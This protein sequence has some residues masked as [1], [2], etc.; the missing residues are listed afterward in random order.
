LYITMESP[1]SPSE[2]GAKNILLLLLP[3]NP[4]PK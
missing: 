1:P 4:H 3:P 2:D